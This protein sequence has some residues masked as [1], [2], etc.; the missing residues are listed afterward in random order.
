[1]D[2]KTAESKIYLRNKNFIDI[3]VPLENSLVFCFHMNPKDKLSM[4]LFY[5]LDENKIL[6][7]F[8]YRVLIPKAECLKSATEYNSKLLRGAK[9][10]RLVGIGPNAEEKLGRIEKDFPPG[11]ILAKFKQTRGLI[12][13]TFIRLQTEKGCRAYFSED[14]ILPKNYWAGLGP[15]V[16]L[17]Q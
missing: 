2:I 7:E 10:V 4:V 14:C 15:Q 17:P 5:A 6:H 8:M 11:S 12:Y 13:W 16:A 9:T 1:L 3:E